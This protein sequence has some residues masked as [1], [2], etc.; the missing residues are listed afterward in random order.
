MTHDSPSDRRPLT[1]PKS[2]R[3]HLQR[4]FRRVFE[5]RCVV[6]D[7]LLVVYADRNGRPESRIGIVASRKLGR[8]VYRNRLKRLI[9]EAFRLDQHDLP[10]GLDVICIPKRVDA[11][12]RDAYRA[13]LAKLLE[14]AEKKLQRTVTTG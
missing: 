2:L 1:F 11:P 9:R 6:S 10:A 13:S 7:P 12:S 3:L 4:D 14:R 8:A 5:R